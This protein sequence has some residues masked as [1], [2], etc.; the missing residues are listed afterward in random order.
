M[1]GDRTPWRSNWGYLWQVR[2]KKS[3]FSLNSHAGIPWGPE[4]FVELRDG[5]VNLRWTRPQ[6]A[7][8]G[9]LRSLTYLLEFF[10]QGRKKFSLVAKTQHRWFYWLNQTRWMPRRNGVMIQWAG[11]VRH[12]RCQATEF[13]EFS[14]PRRWLTFFSMVSFGFLRLTYP[15]RSYAPGNSWHDCANSETLVVSLVQAPYWRSL[16]TFK[17]G[18]IHGGSLDC[19]CSQGDNRDQSGLHH[20]F[21]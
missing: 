15:C 4:T 8:V 20:C 11:P 19:F 13:F 1:A 12:S 7:E 21:L 14:P 6:T 9:A 2:L 17:L 16:M 18:V 5:S 3:E 10:R